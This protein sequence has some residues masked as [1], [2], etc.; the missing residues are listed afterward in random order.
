MQK[1]LTVKAERA[2]RM[3]SPTKANGAP[4][5][6]GRPVARRQTAAKANASKRDFVEGA[7]VRGGIVGSGIAGGT[8]EGLDKLRIQNQNGK[9]NDYTN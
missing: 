3:A 8:V 1:D 7:A 2:T 6:I 5:K 9:K 4:R